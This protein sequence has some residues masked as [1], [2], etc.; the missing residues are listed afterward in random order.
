ML[1]SAS[2]RFFGA[3][4][5]NAGR[6]PKKLAE[7]K[8]KIIVEKSRDQKGRAVPGQYIVGVENPVEYYRSTG[9]Y[10][11]IVFKEGK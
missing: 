3:N 7:A 5:L 2:T 6:P 11:I 1:S 8:V 9:G 4:Q 10:G